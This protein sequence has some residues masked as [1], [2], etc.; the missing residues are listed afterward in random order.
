VVESTELGGA[1]PIP[2]FPEPPRPAAPAPV[3]RKY[4]AAEKANLTRAT[5]A[6]PAGILTG[7]R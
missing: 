1:A 5:L 4:S 3:Q 2:K 6:M 7:R